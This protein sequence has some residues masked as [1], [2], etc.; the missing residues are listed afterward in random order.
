MNKK[1]F[2]LFGLCS[3]LHA[4]E[5]RQET[6]H[7]AFRSANSVIGLLPDGQKPRLDGIVS[8][9]E[10]VPGLTLAGFSNLNGPLIADKRGFVSVAMDT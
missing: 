1:L 8:E 3:L 5:L 2:V 9:N 4:G 10:Y 7:V 6:S